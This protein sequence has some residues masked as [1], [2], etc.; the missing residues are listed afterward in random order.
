MHCIGI[1]KNLP[2]L[3]KRSGRAVGLGAKPSASSEVPEAS[4]HLCRVSGQR[5]LQRAI[6]GGL[7]CRCASGKCFVLRP[8]RCWRG[9]AFPSHAKTISHEQPPKQP[10][11]QNKNGSRLGRL[12]SY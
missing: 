6:S 4:G 1:S 7:D 11:A 9:R 5:L 10:L 8:G 2:I 3:C 12:A